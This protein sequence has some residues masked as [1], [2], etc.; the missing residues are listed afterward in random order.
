M[1]IAIDEVRA[2]M[3]KALDLRGIEEETIALIVDDFLGAE[4]EGRSTHGVGKFLLLDA[5]LAER[6]GHP[7]IETE[8]A[9][10]ALVDGNRELGHVAARYCAEQACERAEGEGIGVVGLR[11]ASRFSRLKPYGRLIADRGLIGIVLNNAGPPA[12]APYGSSEPILGTNPICFAFPAT[13][14]PAVFDFATS[15]RVWGEIRQAVLE[16]RDLPAGAFVDGDGLPTTDP[17]SADAVLPF[18]GARGSALCLAIELMAGGLASALMGKAVT[19]EYDLGAVFV[20]LRPRSDEFASRAAALLAD[21]R[22]ARPLVP[23]QVVHVPGE[24]SREER[25]EAE[26][27]GTLELESGVITRLE[28]MSQSLGGGLESDDKLN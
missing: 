2:L 25:S 5:A 1:P 24:R 3:T 4:L 9:A 17:D 28:E 27:R 15:E 18:G 23:G 26:K 19:S 16:E 21:I 20:A 13:D 14:S 6:V 8:A 10:W 11:N 12:V 7:A 22:S